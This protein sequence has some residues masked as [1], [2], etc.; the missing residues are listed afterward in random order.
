MMPARSE[1][2]KTAVWAAPAVRGDTWRYLA[3][4]ADKN[5]A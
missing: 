3:R 1:L 2:R 5:D 4:T